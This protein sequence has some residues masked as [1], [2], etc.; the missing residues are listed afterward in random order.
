MIAGGAVRSIMDAVG[1]KDVLAKALGSSNAQN[2]AKATMEALRGLRS[3]QDLAKLRGKSVSQIIE[4]S[5]VA[6]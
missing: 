1:I 6:A 2:V 5:N 3:A 4:G